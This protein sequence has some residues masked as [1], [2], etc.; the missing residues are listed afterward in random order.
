MKKIINTY[1]PFP[2]KISRKRIFL[3]RKIHQINGLE[4]EDDKIH[5]S[6]WYMNIDPVAQVLLDQVTEYVDKNELVLDVCCNVGRHLNYLEKSGY[7]NL[8]GFDIMKPAIEKM[9]N[10]FPNIDKKN[11]KLGNAVEILPLYPNNSFDWAYTHSA[12]IELIHPSFKTHYEMAR[13]VRKG[14]IF[15][16]NEGNQGYS[17]NYELIYNRAGF[18]TVKKMLVKSSKEYYFTLYVWIKKDYLSDYANPDYLIKK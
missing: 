6:D 5:K 16:L 15:L 7:N 3:G 14:L 18:V 2:L 12:T 9:G 4:W 1:F 8:H 11:I 17:R 10:F 13:I